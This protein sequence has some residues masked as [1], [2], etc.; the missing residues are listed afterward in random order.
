MLVLA[1][2]VAPTAPAEGGT[3]R[4]IGPEGG[5]IT[6]LVPI[7]ARPD[8]VL[9]S[10]LDG[11]IFRS[12]DR[13]ATWSF[14]AGGAGRLQVGSLAPVPGDPNTLFATSRTLG[15]I[16]SIDGGQTWRA[17]AG[18]IPFGDVVPVV[19]VA[20]DATRGTAYAALGS[21][22][23]YKTVDGG[24]RWTPLAAGA[25]RELRR[26]V[27]DPRLAGTVYVAAGTGGVFVSTSGGRRWRRLRRG[28]PPDAAIWSLEI[29]PL[30]PQV[31]YLL[32]SDRER[33]RLFRSTNR[34]ESWTALGLPAEPG[35]F[36][37]DPA[38]PATV[39][40]GTTEGILRSSDG[41]TT[42]RATGAT[43]AGRQFAV[44]AAAGTVMA[45][46][47]GGVL[48]RSADG[49]ESWRPVSG[50]RA[51]SA[52]DLAVA[53]GPRFY[54]RV[55]FSQ[56]P[57]L[58]SDDAGAGW[59]P[60]PA[61]ED[62]A[63]RLLGSLFALDP[64]APSTIYASTVRS[65]VRSSDG[66]DHWEAISTPSCLL[67]DSLTIDPVETGNLYVAGLPRVS[68]SCPSGTEACGVYRKLGWADWE[69]IDAELP[70]VGV[71]VA[72][73][74][75]FAPS[76]LYAWFP[77]VIYHSADRGAHWS[78]LAGID[79]L[80]AMAL[81]PTRRGVV[82]AG[83]LGGTGR[84]YDGGATWDLTSSGIP[85][86]FVKQL[87]VDPSDG[88]T[89]Y[90]A[91]LLQVYR[92]SDEG[93]TWQRAGEGLAETVINSITLDPTDLRMLYAATYG[94]GV[95]QLDLDEP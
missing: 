19:A 52:L 46:P 81:D 9:A 25:R 82:Y 91:T 34:G 24:Q 75:P 76:H 92:S 43:P 33:S 78:L 10:F 36:A 5:E 27:A 69:C 65:L 12:G 71:P 58:R 23:L 38:S 44:F 45:K 32:A 67:P 15:V 21:G 66:G 54:A 30:R 7:P 89:L 16:K 42:W 62:P 93:R 84:S 48:H 37:L 4:R 68:S 8:I 3:W 57:W 40:V 6:S 22:T 39:Y 49:G 17:A 60:L 20:A 64:R 61:P 83:F 95:L 31:L 14:S 90:A 11:G 77:W 55:L 87:V 29:D 85:G 41:G 50:M 2:L 73:V 35:S 13:G 56:T 88:R 26:L 51:R 80:S 74:D 63:L 59:T 70:G 72:A 86:E 53:P 1:A 79:F 94:G 47:F 18:G 28:L